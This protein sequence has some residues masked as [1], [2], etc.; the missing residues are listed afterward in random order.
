MREERLARALLRDVLDVG[1]DRV[2]VTVGGD[3]LDGGLLA[4]PLHAGD[5]VARVADEREVVDRALGR[6]AEALAPVLDRDPVLVHGGGAAAPGVEELHAGADELV[7]VLVARDDDDLEPGLGPLLRERADDVVGLVALAREH[8]DPVGGEHRL[9][10]LEAAV[11][12]GLQVVGQLLARRLVVGVHLV[13]EARAGVVHPAEVLRPALLE[14]AAEEVRD[15]PGDARVL[16][17]AGG[18][19]AVDEREEG[20]V[21]ERV[22][23]DEEEARR[24]RRGRHAANLRPAARGVPR[25]WRAPVSRRGARTRTRRVPLPRR[26]AGCR[27]GATPAARPRRPRCR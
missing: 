20:A 26:R 16:A 19:R 9:H 3:Q 18:E 14:Q 1:E 10:V 6:D 25:A 27:R 15:P 22:A 8:R 11:E 12:V 13:A 2:E 7:E 4:D 5:V 24:G 17:L 21:D 23:V